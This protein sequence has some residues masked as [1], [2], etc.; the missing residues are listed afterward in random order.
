VDE[1]MRLYAS[2]IRDYTI[3]A[4]LEHYTCM[5]NLLG[6][7]GHLQEA[8]NMLKAMPCKA[9]VAAWTT[10]LGACRI[11]GNLEMA[12]CVAKHVLELEPENAASSVLL[13]NIYTATGN[14][15][16]CVNVE[17]QGKEKAL[18]KQPGLKTLHP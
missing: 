4:K 11:Y 9:D 18:K 1:G 15:H 2:I 12:E 13:A 14:R 5:A 16:H 7:A 17:L 3:P 6:C 8:E 10:L